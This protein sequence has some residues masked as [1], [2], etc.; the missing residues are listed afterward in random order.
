MEMFFVGI[1]FLQTISR[2]PQSANLQLLYFFYNSF[3]VLTTTLPLALVFGWVV[4]LVYF[5]K[6]NSIISFYAL[7]I[8]KKQ[9]IRPI[10]LISSVITI[11]FMFLQTTK[12][13]YAQ[14]IKNNIIHNRFFVNE[15]NNIFLKYND[16]FV[17]FKK[18]YPLEKKAIDIHIFKVQNHNVVETIIAKKAYY[19]NKKWYV[20]DA[21][22]IKKPAKINWNN[23]KLTT[24]QEK[25][26]YTLDGFKPKIIDS[27]Y[28]AKSHFS[29]TDAIYTIVLFKDQ[30]FNINKVKAILYAQTIVPFFII[31]LIIFVFLY[32]NASV[33]FFN[34]AKFISFWVFISLISWATI[35]LLEKLSMGGI[36]IPEIAIILPLFILYIVSYI[37]YTTRLN[38]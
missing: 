35:F 29:I 36:V 28:K 20:I 3:F 4:T 14:E 25:F 8:S 15:R 5:I 33:R 18:L 27:V 32:S 37:L 30:N 7:G 13:A 6:N 23:S 11:L 17:Y 31:P 26:L 22:I 12:L 1:D 2:L 10:L 38:R 19:Q 34:T 9:I 21:T 16:Y 24:S